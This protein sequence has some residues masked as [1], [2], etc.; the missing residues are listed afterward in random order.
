MPIILKSEIAIIGSGMGGGMSARALAQK[1]KQVLVLERGYRLPRE[2]QNWDPKE[3]FLNSRYKNAGQWR[4]S[5]GN[6]FVPG[7]HYYVGGNTKVYGASLLRFRERDFQQYQAADGISPAWPFSY[8]DL[9]KYYLEAEFALKVHGNQGEDPTEPWR[10]GDYKYAALPHEK[11]V[12]RIAQ[13]L[14][15]IGLNPSHMAMGVDIR[16]NGSCIRCKT[17]DGFPCKVGAKSDAETCGI[18]PALATGNTKLVEGIEVTRINHDESGKRIASITASKDGEKYEIIANHYILSAGA[19]NSA[20]L[21]LKSKS[22]KHPHGLANSSGLVGKNWMV[23]NAT[24][25]VG[26]NPFRRNRTDFQ[27]TLMLNDWYWDSPKGIPLGNVQMLGKL[28]AAMFK[29]AR[30]WAPNWA[31]KFLAEHS[32]DIYLE[33][34]DLPSQ[35]NK[36]TVDE[37]GVIRIHWKANNMRSHTELVKNAKKMLHKVGFPIVLKETMGIETNSHM[38]GTLVAGNDPQKSVLDSYCKAHDLENLYVIDSSFFPSS[39]AANPALT[40]AAQAFRIASEVEFN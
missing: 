6:S 38:C 2:K 16:E 15:K 21:L 14:K 12:G 27:K 29:G 39:A 9:E 22:E 13:K 40:I 23:H 17:C 19:A 33:S 7:V 24:F 25:M 37:D 30:P 35:E 34:E 32:F 28:Q 11:Y 26:F 18:D 31:L 36:V 8:S 1:G 20:A 4:D 5:K 3:V 10:S